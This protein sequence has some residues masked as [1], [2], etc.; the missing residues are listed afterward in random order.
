M[1]GIG[2]AGLFWTSQFISSPKKIIFSLIFQVFLMYIAPIKTHGVGV[3]LVF[4]Q[5]L[6]VSSIFKNLIPQTCPP[7]LWKSVWYSPCLPKVNFFTWILMHN[8]VLSGENLLKRE[9]NG[10]FHCCFCKSTTK[11]TN[12]LLIDCVFSKSVWE[13]VL[14]DSNISASAHSLVI[15]FFLSWHDCCPHKYVKSSD[16]FNFWHSIP[17]FT[18]WKLWIARNN[19]IF[20]NQVTTPQSMDLK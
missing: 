7:S 5:L 13:L 16:W 6:M 17:K 18:W 19:W 14:H 8:K 9:F 11:T 2:L 3:S 1:L 20:N 12:H 4:T 15:S 10:P